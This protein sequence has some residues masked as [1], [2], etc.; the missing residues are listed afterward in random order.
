MCP[1]RQSTS[2]ANHNEDVPRPNDDGSNVSK[3]RSLFVHSL[4]VDATTEDLAEHFSQSFPIKHAIVVLDPVTKNGKGY[5]FVTFA[6]AA[7]AQNAKNALDGSKIL[8]KKIRVGLAEPRR[9]L[10]S[11][12]DDANH[13]ALSRSESKRPRLLEPTRSQKVPKLIVRNLPWS[14]KKSD[15]L[16]LLFSSYGKLKYATIPEKPSGLSAGYGFITFQTSEHA[17]K[18]IREMNGQEV[19]GRQLAVD[20]A[21]DKAIWETLRGEAHN[22]LASTENP[23]S[24]CEEDSV[25]SEGSD[26]HDAYDLDAPDSAQTVRTDAV[27]ILLPDSDNKSETSLVR[28][29]SD[30]SSTLFVRNVPFHTTDED[31]MK[32]FMHFGPVRYGRIVFDGLTQQSRGTA[33]V[34]FYNAVDAQNCVRDAPK[35]GSSLI[36]AA[37]PGKKESIPSSK[38]S[39]LQNNRE[40]LYGRYTLQDRVLQISRAVDKEEAKRL[41]VAKT[42][43]HDYTNKDKRRLFL[44]SEGSVSVN[45]PLYQRLSPSELR[46][47]EDSAKQ[48]QALVKH[49]P[50]LHISMT[51]LSVRNLPRS[52]SSKQLKELARKAIVGFASDVKSGVRRPLSKEELTRSGEEMKQAEKARKLKGKGIVK[53]AK[54]VFESL[55]GGKV[56]EG[57]GGGRSRGYGFIEYATHRSALM[58][59]R[60]LNGHPVRPSGHQANNNSGFLEFDHKRL[61]VEFAIENAQVVKR[62]Q[63]RENEARKRPN[64]FFANRSLRHAPLA[65]PVDDLRAQSPPKRRH[66]NDAEPTKARTSKVSEKVARKIETLAKRQHIIAR[67]RSLRRFT[68]GSVIRK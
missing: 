63:E 57:G 3:I 23:E 41:A 60:W 56:R 47:R 55:E 50:A 43:S 65:S 29:T 30:L 67:K 9:R 61:I 8:G 24:G 27:D 34:C 6:D 48:R 51:R 18:A 35:P 36:T 39:L 7:G 4:P 2:R 68:K 19:D 59:L 53:Q 37:I 1:G 5:G 64:S 11:A 38:H 15:Q 26:V 62:R 42:T 32:H 13:N 17:E 16:A 12:R 46:L 40:D 33:F 44:L 21:V 10:R 49:N 54:I 66:D 22:E 14:I 28:E 25:K 58:G 31:I 45:D 52:V 20:Y